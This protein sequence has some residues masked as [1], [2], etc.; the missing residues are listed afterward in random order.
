MSKRGDGDNVSLSGSSS[1]K[2][3][4]ETETDASITAAELAKYKCLFCHRDGNSGNPCPSRHDGDTLAFVSRVECKPCRNY[5]NGCLAGLDKKTLRQN[6]Q[7]DEFLRQY[8]KGLKEHE[9]LFEKS[10]GQ[11]LRGAK[12][13]VSVPAWVRQLE[14]QGFESKRNVGIFWPESVL[15]R[16][17][18]DFVERDLAEYDGEKGLFREKKHG[19]P[20]G[21]VEVYKFKRSFTQRGKELGRDDQQSKEQLKATWERSNKAMGNLAVEV[22][23]GENG[24]DT[25]GVTQRRPKRWDSD[26]S[27]DVGVLPGSTMGF[28]LAV[29]HSE[30]DNADASGGPGKRRKKPTAT[31]KKNATPETDPPPAKAKLIP[32]AAD[33]MKK[34]FRVFPSIQMRALSAL[35]HLCVDAESL[36]SLVSDSKDLACVGPSKLKA[37]ARKLESKIATDA[38]ILILTASN[39]YKLEGKA[40][41]DLGLRG[42]TCMTKTNRFTYVS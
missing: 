18:V 4:K 27:W 12:D 28:K 26:E 3:R 8:L 7:D 22:E 39:I 36:L 11:Q 10:K 20:T 35:D 5:Y 42:A 16:E 17:G 34:D 1:A 19:E 13:L 38:A 15:R 21:S 32:R 30:N 41:E 40:D 33:K 24:Q 29:I 37:M 25:I 9:E 2:R 31:P 23:K 14:E 6:N